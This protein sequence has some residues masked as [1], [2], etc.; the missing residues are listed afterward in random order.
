MSDKV[1]RVNQ[2]K[3]LLTEIKAKKL[4]TNQSFGIKQQYVEVI[5][6]NRQKFAERE[7]DGQ[8]GDFYYYGGPATERDFCKYM[9]K[10][11]KV[12]SSGEIEQLG[13]LLG[14]MS[15]DGLEYVPGEIMPNGGPGGP[16]CR[17]YWIK[18]RGKIVL[19]PA[20]TENQIRTLVSKSVFE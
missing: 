5:E 3:R 8:D 16:N 2:I 1:S 9:F 7:S 18:F 19:T 11:D 4:I 17:H 12:F 14:Y 10:V 6:Y 20:P 15:A 13:Q